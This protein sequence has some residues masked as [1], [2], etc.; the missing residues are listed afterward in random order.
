MSEGKHL[1]SSKMSWKGDEEI[2]TKDV[3]YYI[4][5]FFPAFLKKRLDRSKD[6]REEARFL[7]WAV[8]DRRKA[9]SRNLFDFYI[10]CAVYFSSLL[11]FTLL[12]VLLLARKW[13]MCREIANLQKTQCHFGYLDLEG[14]EVL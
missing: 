2:C 6:H 10:S 8:S 13:K 14:R 4:L 1:I 5:V 12:N 9:G 11:R 3:C 7:N